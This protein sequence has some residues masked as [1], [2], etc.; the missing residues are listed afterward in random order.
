MDP[1]ETPLIE[2]QGKAD[3]VEY[4][5]KGR[6][7]RSMLIG[8]GMSDLAA[9]PAVDLVVGFGGVVIRQGVVDGAEIFIKANRLVYSVELLQAFVKIE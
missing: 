4:L 9:R 1:E 3:V 5:L 2:S 8:D 6:Y 7:G